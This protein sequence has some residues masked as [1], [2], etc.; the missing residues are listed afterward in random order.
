MKAAVL[1]FSL[2]LA[3]LSELNQAVSTGR[4][5]ERPV[6]GSTDLLHTTTET[7][8]Q[9]SSKPSGKTGQAA[10]DVPRMWSVQRSYLTQTRLLETSSKVSVQ[11]TPIKRKGGLVVKISQAMSDTMKAGFISGATNFAAFQGSKSATTAADADF[12]YVGTVSVSESNVPDYL[13]VTL[14]SS[15]VIDNKYVAIAN[16]DSAQ[17]ISG[18]TLLV[19]DNIVYFS[20]SKGSGAKTASVV[21]AIVLMA[22]SCSCW[23]CG[24]PQFYHLIKVAQMLYMK[25]LLVNPRQSTVLFWLLSAFNMNIFRVVPNPVMINEQNGNSCQPSDVFFSEGL[26]CHVYNTLKNYVLGFLIYIVLYFFIHFNIYDHSDFWKNLKDITKINMFMLAIFPDV[27]I[28]IFGNLASPA[29]NSV[30]ST[31]VIFSIALILWYAQIF[32]SALTTCLKGGQEAVDFVSHYMFSRSATTADDPQLDRK[33][34]AIFLEY[35][36]ILIVVLMIGLFPSAPQTQMVIIFVAYILNG[37]FLIIVRPYSNLL[38]NLL[39]ALSDLAFFVLVLMNF[40]TYGLDSTANESS[41]ESGYAT[42]QVIMVIIILFSNLVIYILPVGKGQDNSSV[43][44]SSPKPEAPLRP[45]TLEEVDPQPSIPKSSMVKD[46]HHL[47]KSD[48]HIRDQESPTEARL[49]PAKLKSGSG[50]VLGG[51]TP[52]VPPLNAQTRQEEEPMMP[53]V[54]ENPLINSGTKI[55]KLPPITP[56][57]GLLEKTNDKDLRLQTSAFEAP[58]INNLLG[59]KK[60]DPISLE[61]SHTSK[62]S[63]NELERKQLK[64]SNQEV[65]EEK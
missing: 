20:D 51:N 8:T 24:V 19:S 15:A 58:K 2:V 32:Y 34:L 29:S 43:A 26:S 35:F 30:L 54:S 44:P 23:I 31:G 62:K 53:K 38:H 65:S 45:F 50:R 9:E 4:L 36:K 1:L 37:L 49:L 12:S 14:P 33:I 55:S 13:V 61:A 60:P 42:V 11:M 16:Y 3:T 41:I 6:G 10:S 39:L 59:G 17:K 18:T 52:A 28:G 27:C 25:V 5:F 46:L 64:G 57:E 48:Q 22:A 21:L 40:I 7:E 56:P 47:P 63:L